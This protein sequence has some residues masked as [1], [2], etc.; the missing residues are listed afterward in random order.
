MTLFE[1]KEKIA[2][3]E[4]AI[5]EDA[6][7]IAEK[8]ADPATA[9]EELTARKSHRDELAARRDMLDRKSVV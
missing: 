6:A 2:T 8:A 7:W 5:G 4:A 1:L 9:M 3:L